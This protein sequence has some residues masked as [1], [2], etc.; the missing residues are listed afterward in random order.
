MA[1]CPL[2]SSA[3]VNLCGPGHGRQVE[4][5]RAPIQQLAA[6][7]VYVVV[8]GDQP[9]ATRQG[10][11]KHDLAGRQVDV[12]DGKGEVPDGDGPLP[13]RGHYAIRP[14]L[15]SQSRNANT[16]SGP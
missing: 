6:T 7:V 8:A 1:V 5:A 11:L 13:A 9:H 10:A 14:L 16:S 12:V 4:T 2:I 3:N 15:S